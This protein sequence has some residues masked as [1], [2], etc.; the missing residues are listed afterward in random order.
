M[1]E[2]KDRE[3]LHGRWQK[4]NP[5]WRQ[6]P[7]WHIGREKQAK[8]HS[9]EGTYLTKIDTVHRQAMTRYQ[10]LHTQKQ[11]DSRYVN[12]KGNEGGPVCRPERD[13]GR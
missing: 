9:T 12:A 11:D 7:K 10:C 3:Q 8:A 5:V 1:I 2:P 6:P 4:V 13:G